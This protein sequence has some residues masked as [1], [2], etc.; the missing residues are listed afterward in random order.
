MIPPR[1]RTRAAASP[2]KIEEAAAR[3]LRIG[4]REMRADVAL[5]ERA[6]ERVGE[7]VQRHVG[8]GMAGERAI[9]RDAD[10]AEPDV[11]AG[12]EGVDVETLAD[13]D[14]A[15]R[16]QQP[17]LGR[18]QILHRRHLGVVRVALEDMGRMARPGGDRAV[19]GQVADAFAARAP[20]RLEDQIEA[21]GLRRLHRAQRGAIRRSD[22]A[23]RAVDLLD[24]VG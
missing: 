5:A 24:R 21:E 8:V 20:M 10:A 2:R 16:V 4:R 13:A 9:V 12:R 7:R 1:A 23:A 22:D 19:V 6:I 3:Q 18:A 14:V 15:R 11:I 17:R